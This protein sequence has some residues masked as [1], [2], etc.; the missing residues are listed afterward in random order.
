MLRG[1]KHYTEHT[2]K[3]EKVIFFVADWRECQLDFLPLVLGWFH[4]SWLGRIYI[5]VE[6]IFLRMKYF[7]VSEPF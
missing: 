3:I 2:G 1:A 5:F 7:I 6:L 4:P